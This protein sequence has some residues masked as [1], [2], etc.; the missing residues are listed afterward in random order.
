M[1]IVMRRLAAIIAGVALL[2]CGCATGRHAPTVEMQPLPGFN[3]DYRGEVGDGAD[4]T[5][6]MPEYTEPET[7][8]DWMYTMDVRLV[9]CSRAE[10]VARFG[11][12]VNGVGAW[13]IDSALDMSKDSGLSV[14]AA[15]RLTLFEKQTGTISIVNQLSY[16]KSFEIRSQGDT[17]VADPVIDTLSEGLVLALRVQ[18][19]D[20]G[21]MKIDL[22][23][24]Q[25]SVVRP[26]E[27]QQVQIFGAPMTIQTPV[28][29]TQRLKAQGDVSED[30]TLILTGLIDSDDQVSLVLI[31]GRR[32]EVN[33]E[34]EQPKDK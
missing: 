28:M 3:V 14:V 23:L 6:D 13:A 20:A 21:S 22:D 30:R 26:I 11:E 5:Q 33:Y 18:Q 15:P 1:E 16:V 31:N 19:A 25:S 9:Q 34:P 2:A 4:V 12:H 7:R 17:L 29:Y 24:T 27:S 32:T 8:P 10:A